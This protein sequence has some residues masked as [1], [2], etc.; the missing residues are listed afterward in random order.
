MANLGNDRAPDWLK[1]PVLGFLA[2]RLLATGE[3]KR[4]RTSGQK[5]PDQA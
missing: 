4:R 3:R 2:R 1:G 5:R